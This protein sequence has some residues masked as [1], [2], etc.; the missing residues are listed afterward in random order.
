MRVGFT[1][2]SQPIASRVMSIEKALSSKKI[3]QFLK[4]FAAPSRIIKDL[5]SIED[6]SLRLPI[7][8]T[9]RKRWQILSI[10]PT[11]R[12]RCL[13]SIAV[14]G[15]SLKST[16]G[17]SLTH[18]RVLRCSRGHSFCLKRI[19]ME[20]VGLGIR[21]LAKTTWQFLHTFIR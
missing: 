2:E 15:Q 14:I 17:I 9:M 5:V 12:L 13:N 11:C 18:T 8:E 3:L 1:K 20:A 10:C 6:T 21:S 16:L 4:F 19:K 7:K